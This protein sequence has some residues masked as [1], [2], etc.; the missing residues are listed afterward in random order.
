V[1]AL[2]LYLAGLGSITY[3]FYEFWRTNTVDPNAFMVG[4]TCLGVA[5]ALQVFADI[6]RRIKSARSR[7]TGGSR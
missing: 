4:G 6:V 2:I 1:R 7:R 5:A 3:G